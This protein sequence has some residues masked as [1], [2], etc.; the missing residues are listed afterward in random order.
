MPTVT[1]I[2]DSKRGPNRKR[3]YLDGVFA[4]SLNLNVVA[5]F[6]LREGLALS[7]PEV[8]KIRNGEVRQECFDYAMKQ[9]QMRLHSAAE[10]SRKLTRKEYSPE[11]IE[12]VL[13]DLS[14]MGYVDDER[15]AKTRAMSAAQYKHHGRRRAFQELIR[16]GVKKDVAERALDEVYSE[17]GVGADQLSTARDL[18]MKKAA[19]LKRLAPDV[20]KRRLVG[21]LQRRGFDYETI[22]PVIEEVLGRE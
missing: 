16:S 15:F 17:E 13:A 6:R 14:R 2:S 12:G 10:L 4:F 5:R 3:I 1:Q 8:E 7:E 22:K 11:M 18:A 21:M 9:L 20:A 19:S